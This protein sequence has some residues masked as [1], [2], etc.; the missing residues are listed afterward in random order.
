MAD[1]QPP[2]VMEDE[3]PPAVMEEEKPAVMESG[4]DMAKKRGPVF[5]TIWFYLVFAVFA[6]VA[7]RLNYNSIFL[8]IGWRSMIALAGY[9]IMQVGLWR[10][11]H[12]WD[13]EG[14]AA[15][16]EAAGKDKSSAPEDLE[17]SGGELATIPA[18][19]LKAAFP[20]PWGFLIGWWVWGISYLFPLDG[21]RD[22]DPTVFGIVA[23][24]VCVFVSLVASVPMADAVMN[25][26]PKKKM[27]LSLMF[28]LG[29][30][31]LGVMSA[32]DVTDQVTG[33]DQ[34]GIWV[35]CMLG[36][37]TVIVSQKI[38]FGSRK[39]GTL[40]EESGKPNFRPVSTRAL[41]FSSAYMS[42]CTTC[43]FLVDV[44]L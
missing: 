25:R 31:V 1:D 4:P 8:I 21:T 12:K 37:F 26:T 43:M 17:K 20:I 6:I 7:S 30:I 24:V 2:T 15:W 9:L 5:G 38:L 29:W 18:D 39:M 10:A 44:P 40:W 19:K 23:L 41:I 34:S 13:E 3:Q 28:L 16:L 27:I 22:M 14:S 11:E 36:P 35:L 42:L 33:F 32:L